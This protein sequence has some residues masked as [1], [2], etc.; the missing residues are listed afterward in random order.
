MEGEVEAVEGE[1][2]VEEGRAILKVPP[3]LR[4]EETFN[5][6]ESFIGDDITLK[7]YAVTDVAA[8]Y[9]GTRR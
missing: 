4:Q 8:S 6:T 2:V 3:K 5:A 7:P 1:E 9:I